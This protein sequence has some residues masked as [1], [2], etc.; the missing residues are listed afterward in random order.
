[1]SPTKFGA[2]EVM[3]TELLESHMVKSGHFLPEFLKVLLIEIVGSLNFFGLEK[4]S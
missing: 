4:R 2:N 3:G 1:M